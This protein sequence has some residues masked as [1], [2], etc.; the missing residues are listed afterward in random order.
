MGVR[1]RDGARASKA[2]GKAE[3]DPIQPGRKLKRYKGIILW[4]DYTKARGLI[5]RMEAEDVTV[6]ISGFRG[7]R[8]G[9]LAAGQ[10]VEFEIVRSLAGLR[11]IDVV[12]C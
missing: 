12:L 11:A 5:G 2:A 8:P 7:P 4:F 3:D 1:A 9:T 10:R 6:L